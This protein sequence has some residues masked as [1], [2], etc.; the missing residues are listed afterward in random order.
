MKFLSYSS[1]Y[2]GGNR[3][4]GA[5]TTLHDVLR[6]LK[7]DYQVQALLSTPKDGGS[8]SYVIDGVKVQGFSSK[9]DPFMWFPGHTVISQLECAARAHLVG[10]E[11]GVPTIQLVHNT[12]E[13][14]LGISRFCDLNV[15]NCEATRL[16][17]EAYGVTKRSVVMYPLIDP[18][19]Y[20]VDHPSADD[21]YVT[22]IN[23]SDGTAPFYDKGY[24]TFY[25]LAE[26]YPDLRFLGVIGGYGTQAIRTDLPNVTFMDHTTNPLEIYRKTSV[27]LC[28]ATIESFGRVAVEAAASGI[29]SISSNLPGPMEA[30]VSIEYL[31]PEDL[32]S[33]NSSLNAILSNYQAYS[34]YALEASRTISYYTELQKKNFLQ[35]IEE[36]R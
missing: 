35:M 27:L 18:Q 33:W 31:D 10:A 21:G 25:G 9:R 28:P 29:P 1:A 30:N 34:E 20:R 4:A 17:H 23:L 6:L 26:R 14:S 24:R 12:T 36:M 11:L 32:D 19:L 13:Y 7:K 22:L 16:A 8:E 2:V 3:N 5:E 15:Y